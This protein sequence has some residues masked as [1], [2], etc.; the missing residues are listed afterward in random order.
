MYLF[1]HNQLKDTSKTR[2]E[3]F[4]FFPH[5]TVKGTNVGI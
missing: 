2:Q 3:V 1:G 5:Y 4:H